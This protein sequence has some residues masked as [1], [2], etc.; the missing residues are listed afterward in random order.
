MPSDRVPARRIVDQRIRNRIIEYLELASSFD[1][2]RAYQARA[3]VSVPSELINQWEDW[4]SDPNSP[5]FAR[6][7]FS[8]AE[9]EAILSFHCVWDSVASATPDPLPPLEQTLQLP[10]WSELRRAAE[11]ALCVFTVQG[12]LP[13]DREV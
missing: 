13:E 7:P 9:R 1:A 3:P 2:Q 6:P 4:V 8:A 10:Q 12:R 5:V 11:R